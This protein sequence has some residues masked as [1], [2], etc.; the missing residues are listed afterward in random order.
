MIEEEVRHCWS[1]ASRK[2][3]WE[4]AELSRDKSHAK[5]NPSFTKSTRICILKFYSSYM[6]N[7][8]FSD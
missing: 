3:K 7:G 6:S 5:G 1:E 2:D 4:S 8:I